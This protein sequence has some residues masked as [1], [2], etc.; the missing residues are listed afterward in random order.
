M[1]I[2]LA[3]QV[4]TTDTTLT[5]EGQIENASG[6]GVVTIGSEQISYVGNSVNQFLGCVR[7]Y[8]STTPAEHLIGAPVTYVTHTTANPVLNSVTV[9]GYPLSSN[10]TLTTTDIADASNKRYC[11]DAQKTVIAATSNTNTGDETSATIKTKLANLPLQLLASDPGSPTEGMFWYN[12]TTHLLKFY[13]G[14]TV[15]TVAHV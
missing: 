1:S 9:N 11:T 10:V 3:V 8:N 12:T 7:G 14:S 15:Q 5:I 6:S 2:F 4:G 13:D